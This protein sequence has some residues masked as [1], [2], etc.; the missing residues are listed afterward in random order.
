[1]NSEQK[2]LYITLYMKTCEMAGMKTSSLDNW[3]FTNFF[4]ILLSL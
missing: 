1:M 3:H 4:F 2:Q